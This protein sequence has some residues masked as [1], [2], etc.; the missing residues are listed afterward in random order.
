[1]ISKSSEISNLFEGL[2]TQCK[3]K[4]NFHFSWQGFCQ[5]KVLIMAKSLPRQVKVGFSFA[6][7][8]QP[9]EIIFT[10]GFPFSLAKIWS[11]HISVTC[12]KCLVSLF[13]FELYFE[14]KWTKLSSNFLQY[15]FF[16]KFL[17]TMN[18]VEQFLGVQNFSS[19]EPRILRS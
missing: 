1:M 13:L 3:A 19:Q 2:A 9:F 8:G 17:L 7:G 15:V 16:Q 4:T 5:L 14:K 18:S 12:P 10:L 11:G 6:L